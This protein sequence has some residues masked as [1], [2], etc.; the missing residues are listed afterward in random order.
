MALQKQ[1]FNYFWL[2]ALWM[3]VVSVCPAPANDIVIIVN[4]GVAVESMEKEA[5]RDLFLGNISVW[6]DDKKINFAIL[7][8]SETHQSFVQT[9]TRKTESQFQAWWKR[10][11]FTGTGKFPPKFSTDQEMID[12]VAKTEGGLGYVSSGAAIGDGVKILTVTEK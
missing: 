2:I 11:L 6:P 3:C 12:Y 10:K 1:L 5:L 8:S 9:Y 4:K 7:G